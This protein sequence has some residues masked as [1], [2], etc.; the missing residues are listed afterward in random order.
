MGA[1][2]R[3]TGGL[4]L[5][6]LEGSVQQYFQQ[7]LA[8]ST[9]KAYQSATRRFHNFCTKYNVWNPFPVSESL[10]C[11][12]V[13]FLADDGLAPQTCKSYLAAVRNMQLSLGLPDPRDQSSLPVLKRVQAGIS[14]TRMLRGAQARIRL[15]ITIN[16]LEKICVHLSSS[17][18]P[19][20]GWLHGQ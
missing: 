5:S 16:I 4:D 12:F 14:R 1:P 8:P 6:H 11:S 9:R 2:S 17:S 13:A 15:P 3:P 10:L 19:E 7:G 18:D 20:R